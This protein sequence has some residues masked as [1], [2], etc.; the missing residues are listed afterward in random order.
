MK[1]RGKTLALQTSW[2]TSCFQ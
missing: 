1:N 2:Q